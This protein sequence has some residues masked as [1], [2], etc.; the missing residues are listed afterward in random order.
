MKLNPDEILHEASR[1][2]LR[3]KPRG[4]MLEVTPKSRLT[5][6]FVAVLREHKAELLVWLESRACGLPSDCAAWLHVAR[7]ILAGE[8]EG[9][10]SSTVESLIIGLRSIQHPSCQQALSRLSSLKKD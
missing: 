8:F 1:L 10:D 2:G 9:A 3:L 4:E 6:E 5:P 7:Q